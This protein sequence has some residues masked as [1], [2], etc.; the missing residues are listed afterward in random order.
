MTD[1]SA[2]KSCRDRLSILR[3]RSAPEWSTP[4]YKVPLEIRSRLAWRASRLPSIGPRDL[5]SRSE[6]R[7]CDALFKRLD[8]E[9]SY[10][11]KEPQR[12]R[13]AAISAAV[14]RRRLGLERYMVVRIARADGHRVTM[15]VLQLTLTRGFGYSRSELAWDLDGRSLRKNGTLGQLP[16]RMTFT[17]AKIAVRTL[18]GEWRPLTLTVNW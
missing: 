14:L 9:A 6:K 8:R 17:Q 15:Q 7:E 4:E 11:A 12:A 5:L 2:G 13:L 18:S 10:E 16:A 1:R 3:F